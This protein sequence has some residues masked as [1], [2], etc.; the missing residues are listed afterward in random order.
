MREIDIDHL[1]AAL[2]EGATVIDVRETS[3]YVDAHV[4]GSRSIPMGQLTDRLD[5]LDRTCPVYVVCASGNRSS[6]MADVLLAQRFDAVNVLGGT[7]AWIRSGR[8]VD[9][10]AE[11]GAAR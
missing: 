5:E 6:A 3:E 8:P 9:S 7:N 11:T 4:P 10:G 2:A 1:A